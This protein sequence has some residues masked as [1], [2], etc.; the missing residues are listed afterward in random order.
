MLT[1]LKKTGKNL[2]KDGKL[3]KYINYA[4]GEKGQSAILWFFCNQVYIFPG[5][6]KKT[7]G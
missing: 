3:I 6:S 1:Q 4:A 5:I 7:N 2:L